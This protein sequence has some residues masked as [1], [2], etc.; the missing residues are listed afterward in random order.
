MDRVAME[1]QAKMTTQMVAICKE[2]TLRKNHSTDQLSDAEKTQF[3][4][5][6]MKYFETPNHIMGAMQGGQGGGF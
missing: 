2:R 3:E 6:L 4:N 1:A 5:C